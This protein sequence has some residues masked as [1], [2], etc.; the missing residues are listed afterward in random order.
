MFNIQLKKEL[1]EVK[2]QL[3]LERE[4]RTQMTNTEVDVK[5]KLSEELEE[6]RAELE[7]LKRSRKEGTLE[8]ERI[9]VA[10]SPLTYLT[11]HDDELNSNMLRCDNKRLPSPEQH[12]LLCQSTNQWN[13]LVSQAAADLIQD[14]PTVLDSECLSPQVT[15]DLEDARQNY[16]VGSS[17]SDQAKELSDVMKESVSSD[18]EKEVKRLQKEKMKEKER[19]DQYHVKLEALQK[20]V[21]RQTQQLTMAFEKQSQHISGLLAELQ[22]KERALLIQGEELHHCKQAL[23]ALKAQKEAEEQKSSEVHVTFTEVEEGKQEEEAPD[24]KSV[25]I[26]ELQPKQEKE[27]VALLS[28]SLPADTECDAGQPETAERPTPVHENET[29]SATAAP[30]DSVDLDKTHRVTE[31][32]ESDQHV[33]PTEELA[34]LL[35]L[36]NENQ[37][38]KQRLLNLTV[39]YSNNQ[40]LHPD[41]KQKDPSTQNPNTENSAVP[42]LDEPSHVVLNDVTTEE[43]RAALQDT[44][45]R[46]EEEESGRADRGTDEE[47]EKEE[48]NQLVIDHLQQQVVELCTQLRSLSEV[49]QQQAEELLMWRLASKPAPTFDLTSTS[50]QSSDGT[51]QTQVQAPEG[52]SPHSAQ[53]SSGT[54]T[55]I[56]EDELLLSGSSNKLQGRVLL[57]RLQHSSFPE[58]RSLQPSKNTVPLQDYDKD[59]TNIEDSEP[60]DVELDLTSPSDICQREDKKKR[61]AEVG[62][63]S[64]EETAPQHCTNDSQSVCEPKQTQAADCHLG[65]PKVTPGTS[66]ETGKINPTSD[67]SG[68]D[69]RTEIKSVSSQTEETLYSG[70]AP[71]AAELRCVS[72]QTE[73]TAEEEDEEELVESPPVSPIPSDE[74]AKSGDK[75]LFSGSFP[76][77]ADPARLAERIR[78]NRTQLSAAFDDTEYEPYGLPEVVMK[79]F[80]DIPTGPS[81]PYIVRRGLLGTAV[82]PVPQKN[83]GQE[84]ETD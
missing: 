34:E 23:D 2:A 84:K 45:R 73:E 13:T 57:S 77:P 8:D 33:G 82:V 60:E 59:S 15:S 3:A 29:H 5:I 75:M 9:S 69:V 37:L 55:V 83:Q 62:Q 28:S 18:L 71:A 44:K 67:S 61:A 38:L 46:E 21:T 79:G 70:R 1:A 26:S 56:R 41:K 47:E 39:S 7:E 74:A 58:S 68:R 43:Q 32:T 22:E 52:C 12:I 81:C 10:N 66:K 78:R 63:M 64:A 6:L 42:C 17:L 48:E 20:Q 11:L 72:T 25:E 31:G 54:I 49:T 65:N 16:L 14:E 76:I 36:R 50:N 35:A 30:L 4:E 51:V 53:E 27:R 80:A 40:A 19:A 24:E